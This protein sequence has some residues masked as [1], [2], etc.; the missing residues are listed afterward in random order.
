MKNSVYILTLVVLFIMSAQIVRA[1]YTVDYRQYYQNPQTLNPA[2]AGIDGNWSFNLGYGSTSLDQDQKASNYYIGA[3]LTF[4]K[5][6]KSE[7]DVLMRY[8]AKP[9][10][11]KRKPGVPRKLYGGGQVRHGFGAT[12]YKRDFRITSRQEYALTYA[13]HVPLSRSLMVSGGAG[14]LS[15]LDRIHFDALNV[16][17]EMDPIYQDLQEGEDNWNYYAAQVGVA[18]HSRRIYLG[19]AFKSKLRSS[20]APGDLGAEGDTHQMSGGVRFSLSPDIE[21]LNSANVGLGLDDAKMA[22][23]S[24][25]Q[26]KDLIRAGAIYDYQESISGILGIA[27]GDYARTDF[28]LAYPLESQYAQ[29]DSKIL[30]EVSLSFFAFKAKSRAKY[31]W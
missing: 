5:I 22:V 21:W 18:I 17:H 15:V 31:F 11:S 25:L 27:I 12:L 6:Q 9:K 14:M 20:G 7:L 30:Y 10:F 28:T 3:N 2:Y 23:T 1:Q 24:Q 4:P 8:C 29:L 19:Y 26:Y 16:R 13:V